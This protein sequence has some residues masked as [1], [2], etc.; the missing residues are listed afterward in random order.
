MCYENLNSESP[1]P[2]FTNINGID[3]DSLKTFHLND[4]DI[5]QNL[6]N[7]ES[8]ALIIIDECQRFF[9]PRPSGSRVPEHVSFFNTHRHLGLDF[10]LITQ[11]VKLIDKSLRDLVGEHIHVSRPFNM[12]KTYQYKWFSVNDDPEP[13]RTEQNALKTPVVLDKNL[14][15]FYKSTELDTHRSSF[16]LKKLYLLIF[17]IAIPVFTFFYLIYHYSSYGESDVKHEKTDTEVSL[18]T[19]KTDLIVPQSIPVIP[20]ETET[21]KPHAV[22]YI[23]S[24]LLTDVF[25][26][27]G[28]KASTYSSITIHKG[29]GY[30][31]SDFPCDFKNA[32]CIV[33]Q[34]KYINVLKSVK[35][36]V[37]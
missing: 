36:A 33:T 14:F 2:I 28:S 29:I 32:K 19:S 11:G 10:V 15:K 22:G 16:P 17:L 27:D 1:R 3:S 6:S 34:P 5:F 9:P 37:F 31:C 35:P 20:T 12:K 30:L 8:G 21:K 25:F 24:D 18:L 26:S 7:F 13:S 23:Q 4:D